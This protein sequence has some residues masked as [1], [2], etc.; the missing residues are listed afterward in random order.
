M[1]HG[2]RTADSIK[3]A[4]KL[5]RSRRVPEGS[6]VT[7]MCSVCRVARD[8]SCFTKSQLK[9]GDAGRKC[10][11]CVDNVA[12]PAGASSEAVA[13][14]GAGRGWDGTCCWG[15]GN[16][17]GTHKLECEECK[18]VVADF[19]ATVQARMAEAKPIRLGATPTEEQLA[20]FAAEEAAFAAEKA[21]AEKVGR[22][23]WPMTYTDAAGFLYVVGRPCVHWYCSQQCAETYKDRHA[24][25]HRFADR[26]TR[27]ARGEPVEDAGEAGQ[28]DPSIDRFAVYNGVLAYS[29]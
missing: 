8:S 24:R 28:V 25:W 15:C 19:N 4:S 6:Q 20:R 16:P 12:P 21:S 1:P 18:A 22:R 29:I 5:E 14:P 26:E 17:P 23:P 10:T 7:L 9:R 13:L 27:R 3:A 11:Y 2:R